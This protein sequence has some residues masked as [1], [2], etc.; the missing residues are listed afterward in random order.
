MSCTEQFPNTDTS[1]ILPKPGCKAN[2]CCAIKV[3]DKAGESASETPGASI[4]S[5]ITWTHRVLLRNY[6]DLQGPRPEV[7]IIRSCS[8]LLQEVQLICFDGR[9]GRRHWHPFQ[10]ATYSP[11][12]RLQGNAKFITPLKKKN[13]HTTACSAEN[14]RL[15]SNLTFSPFRSP[16]SKLCGGCSWRAGEPPAAGPLAPRWVP[17]AWSPSPPKSTSPHHRAEGHVRTKRKKEKKKKVN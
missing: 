8:A 4:C 14:L 10:K 12:K 13:H 7:N 15:V 6:R 11:A 9:T 5:G 3:S 2:N 17:A 16:G 1:L